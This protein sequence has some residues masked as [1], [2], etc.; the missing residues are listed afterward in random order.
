MVAVV[1]L[2]VGLQEQLLSFLCFQ[3]LLRHIYVASLIFLKLIKL[4]F[5][6]QPG[7]KCCGGLENR[8]QRLSFR[9]LISHM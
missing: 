6:S 2:G 1:A 4:I 9:D 3:K 7:T 8:R 5:V